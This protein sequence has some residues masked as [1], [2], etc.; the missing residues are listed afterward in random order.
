MFD[1]E[2]FHRA[3]DGDDYYPAIC[4][5][6]Q[7]QFLPPGEAVPRFSS[8]CTLVFKAKEYRF[9]RPIELVRCMRLLGSGGADQPGTRFVF[10][11]DTPGL[12]I[13]HGGS[14]ARTAMTADFL[15]ETNWKATGTSTIPPRQLPPTAELPLPTG[16]GSVIESIEFI[17]ACTPKSSP[18]PAYRNGKSFVPGKTHYALFFDRDF[19]RVSK[20]EVEKHGTLVDPFES[21]QKPDRRCH[22]IVAYGRFVLRNCVVSHFSGHGIYIYGNTT[23]SNADGWQIDT[24]TVRNNCNNGLHIFGSDATLGLAKNLYALAN[25]FWGVADLSYTGN[26]F[27]GG[28]AAYNHF[29]GFLRPRLVQLTTDPD[30]NHANTGLPLPGM[31]L[32]RWFYG[33][34]NNALLHKDE[35]PV[36]PN[37]AGKFLQFNRFISAYNLLEH[38]LLHNSMIP[39]ENGQLI[40]NSAV[41]A[42]H[43][44]SGYQDTGCNSMSISGEFIPSFD[45]GIRLQDRLSIM[46]FGSDQEKVWIRAMKRSEAAAPPNRSMPTA[47][48]P[49]LPQPPQ[50]EIVFFTDPKAGDYVGSVFCITGKDE[51]GKPIWEHRKFGKIAKS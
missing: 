7:L 40:N 15:L 25:R 9:S 41:P 11:H 47:N 10:T 21:T 51:S 13:H 43:I 33:E 8:G 44:D 48:T 24:V 2:I 38:C 27:I 49:D 32:L 46:A 26:Q 3:S 31:T 22:G 45:T 39:I 16:E 17:G 29:G 4:R 6:Q 18:Y 12:V 1:I 20:A 37:Y 50:P 19:D 23:H 5:A 28:Q 36:L 30:Q 34:D 14:E 35:S 42:L